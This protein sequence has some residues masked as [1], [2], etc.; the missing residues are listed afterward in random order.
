MNWNWDDIWH[1]VGVIVV[2]GIAVFVGMFAFA[3]KNVDYYYLS[4]GGSNSNA[5]CVY[6]HW[7]WHS[8]EKVF[9]TDDY[10]KAIDFATKANA[11]VKK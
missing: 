8:D 5:A 11:T 2:L 3:T 9:C 10:N 4:Q 6:A 7:T 1:S